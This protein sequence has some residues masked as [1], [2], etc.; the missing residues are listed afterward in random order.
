MRFLR[1]RS[2]TADEAGISLVEVIIYSALSAVVLSV[3]GGLVF[4]GFQTHAAV[5][6]RD[7]ATGAAEVVSDSLQTGIRNASI[8]SVSSRLV[9]AR[10]A[11]GASGWQCV[12]WALTADGK[13]AYKAAA[14]P[15]TS[16]DYSAWAVLADE[17]TPLDGTPAFSGSATQLGYSLAFTSGGITVPVA[18][19]VT[20]NAQG[21]GNPETCW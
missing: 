6:G 16:T 10:V 21:T 8:I 7:A 20:A 17:V 11:T 2:S 9:K 1:G 14:V 12:A 15:I 3:L 19:V 5:S 13:L 18:G 4:T